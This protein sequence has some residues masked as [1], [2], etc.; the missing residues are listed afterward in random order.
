MDD[1]LARLKQ[2]F[3]ETVEFDIWGEFMKAN[4]LPEDNPDSYPPIVGN[5]DL[6]KVLE[7]DYIFAWNP[8]PH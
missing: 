1:I 3:K 5:L 4:N 8:L 7:S 2:S 6:N